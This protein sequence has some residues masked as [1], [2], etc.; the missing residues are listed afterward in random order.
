MPKPVTRPTTKHN[1]P[2]LNPGL[3]V[4][5]PAP[6][7]TQSSTPPGLPSK[8]DDDA[9]VVAPDAPGSATPK[10]VDGRAHTDS[11][12]GAGA[13]RG[14]ELKAVLA[15]HAAGLLAMAVDA[16]PGLLAQY[17]DQLPTGER[18]SA[19]RGAWSKPPSAGGKQPA[20]VDSKS[21]D[22]GTTSADAPKGADKPEKTARSV[23]ARGVLPK[24]KQRAS[25]AGPDAPDEGAAPDEGGGKPSRWGDR[26][27][28]DDGGYAPSEGPVSEYSSYYSEDD[29]P[30]DESQYVPLTDENKYFGARRGGLKLYSPSKKHA[31]P[32]K[33]SLYGDPTADALRAS[34]RSGKPPGTL[35]TGYL[36]T[37]QS[38]TYASEA[39]R[40]LEENVEFLLDGN[41]CDGNAPGLVQCLNVQSVLQPRLGAPRAHLRARAPH[42]QRRREE[43]AVHP[44]PLRRRAGRRR[45]RVAAGDRRRAARRPPRPRPT[46][47]GEEHARGAAK[48][49]GLGGGGGR[50]GDDD[51]APPRRQPPAHGA[52]T[53]CERTCA[54]WAAPGASRPTTAA[55]HTYL[56]GGGARA[57]LG[58][59]PGAA[60]ATA[61]RKVKSAFRAAVAVCA[62]AFF[63]RGA[64]GSQ[65]LAGRATLARFRHGGDSSARDGPRAGLGDAHA[66]DPAR[67]DRSPRAAPR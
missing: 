32:C 40:Q 53:R 60:A 26:D 35:E 5:S 11:S 17:L 48:G 29:E 56:R 14:D 13:P 59:R 65:L 2:A 64:T 49:G 12:N 25:D 6:G 62:F 7:G 18:V 47:E 50:R 67:R 51:D 4:Q 41:E 66:H 57:P 9:T 33:H 21:T 61:S 39:I 42:R 45:P 63:A 1:D 16:L 54:A 55:P 15:Q 10:R 20:V 22:A 37:T 28:G 38:L 58:A 31:K 34:R 23:D 43:V 3:T 46:R 52:V 27:D 44:R 24:G 8:L 19:P 36:Y 30:I